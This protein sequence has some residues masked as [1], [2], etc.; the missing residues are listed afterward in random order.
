MVISEYVLRKPWLNCRLLNC[1]LRFICCCKIAEPIGRSLGQLD[2]LKA[3]NKKRRR[4]RLPERVVKLYHAARSFVLLNDDEDFRINKCRTLRPVPA[5]VKEMICDTLVSNRARLVGGQ[6]RLKRQ[7][8]LEGYAEISKYCKAPT[9]IERIMVW[10]VAT[11]KLLQEEEDRRLR[12]RGVR[13]GGGGSNGLVDGRSGT[14]GRQNGFESGGEGKKKKVDLEVGRRSSEGSNKGLEYYKLVAT[15]LSRYCAY[16]V[17]YKPKLLPIASN[18]V[19]YMCNELL[20]EANSEEKPGIGGGGGG[21]DTTGIV[22]RGRR[23]AEGLARCLRGQEGGEITW[24]ALA[25]LWCELIVTM[26]PQ[27]SIAAHQKELGKGG[28][29]I[30]HLWALLYHAGI[31]DKFSGSS[32]AGADAVP[33]R[34]DNHGQEGGGGGGNMCSAGS[35]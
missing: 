21:Q 10:H 20:R 22:W 7:A 1:I 26:A 27:G 17:F 12:R 3:T 15:T 24:K 29:F 32:T 31:D 35:I 5:A 8:D 2:L 28:E 14:E 9:H 23:V 13:A 34:E 4:C 11:S 19:R 18:S 33:G 16:L 6:E 30:T 25:E